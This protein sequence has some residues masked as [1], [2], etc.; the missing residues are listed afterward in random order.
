MAKP[1]RKTRIWEEAEGDWRYEVNDP[2]GHTATGAH[3]DDRAAAT[4]AA[5]TAKFAKT[6]DDVDQAE[7]VE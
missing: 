2:A 3:F 5:K 6:D 1:R 7:V 4:A